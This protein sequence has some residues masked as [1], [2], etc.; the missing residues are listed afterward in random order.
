M[1]QLPMHYNYAIGDD[2]SPMLEGV[3]EGFVCGRVPQWRG[4]MFR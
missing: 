3:A 4:F 1:D 2:N